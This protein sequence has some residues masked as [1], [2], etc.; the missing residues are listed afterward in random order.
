M[1]FSRL[2]AAAQK[3]SNLLRRKSGFLRRQPLIDEGIQ[4]S[5]RTAAPFPPVSLSGEGSEGGVAA[6]SAHAGWA[7]GCTARFKQLPS[8]QVPVRFDK[9]DE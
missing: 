2:K 6:V 9:L 5:G 4:V 1:G 3:L 7:A 8:V